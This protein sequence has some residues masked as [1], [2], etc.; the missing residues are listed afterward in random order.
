M[1]CTTWH[2]SGI[3][4]RLSGFARSAG[5]GRWRWLL[6]QASAVQFQ[7]TEAGKSPDKPDGGGRGMSTVLIVVI[8]VVVIIVLALLLMG[9]TRGRQRAA[10]R[11]QQKELEQ[12]REQAVTE[13]REAAEARAGRAEEA[14]HRARV[15]GAVADRERAEARLHEERARAHEMGLGDEDL[16]RGEQTTRDQ[17]ARGETTRRE[18][19]ATESATRT[20]VQSAPRERNGD[21]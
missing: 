3:A 9:L 8:V 16:M 5:P 21:R 1:R 19:T 20:D 15:A 10:E 14:E 11:R 4:R 18:Q 6:S 7:L 17:T 13:H 12:R 2:G